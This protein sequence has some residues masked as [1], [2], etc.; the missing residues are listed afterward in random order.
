MISKSIAEEIAHPTESKKINNLIAPVRYPIVLKRILAPTDLT[1]GARKAVKYALAL[2]QHFDSQLTIMHVYYPADDAQFSTGNY[3][4]K[5]A[6]LERENAWDALDTFRSEIKQEYPRI[7][8]LLRSGRP[9]EEIVEAAKDL[10]V[11]LIVLST[12]N[13]H[14]FPHLVHG[15][16]AERVLRHAPCPV[17]VV[18]KEEHD[19]VAMD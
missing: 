17:L 9:E 13:Y 16:D 10:D 1:P 15:S 8:T 19:F 5:A 2:A 3:D 18:R 11:D 6:E 14:W 12:H 4:Y 7:D